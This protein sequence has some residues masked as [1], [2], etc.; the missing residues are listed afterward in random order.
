MKILIVEDNQA[1]ILFMREVC[2]AFGW[3]TDLVESGQK[4][5]E[6]LDARPDTYEVVLMDIHMPQMSGLEAAR[7]IRKRDA[8]RDVHTTLIAVTADITQEN[9]RAC[10]AAGFDDFLQKPVQLPALREIVTK[11]M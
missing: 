5:L 2:K 8:E 10:E 11:F 3:D 9:R 6:A 7:E 4:C 1:N